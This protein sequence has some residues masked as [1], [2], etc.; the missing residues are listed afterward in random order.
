M[1]SSG[2][3]CLQEAC[4]FTHVLGEHTTIYVLCI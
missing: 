2:R 3:Y 1:G 4:G